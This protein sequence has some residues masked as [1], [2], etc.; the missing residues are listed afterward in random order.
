MKDHSRARNE[1]LHEAMQEAK[2]TYEKL[3]VDIRQVA[4]EAGTE[5]RT[6]KSAVGHWVRGGE[7]EPST[8]SYI[9]EAIS[10]RLGRQL[11]PADLGFNTPGSDRAREAEVGLAIGPDPVAMLRR[12]GEADIRRRKFL[13]NA[14]YSVAAAALPLGLD[15]ALEYRARAASKQRAGRAELD[16][17]RDM[18]AMFTAIDERHGGQ[19]GRTAVVQYL[20]SDVADLCNATFATADEHR[21]AL[22]LA[23]NVAYLCGWKGYDADEHG[24]AQRYYLQ[25]LAL[26]RE[27]GDDLHAAWILRIMAHNG[28]DIRRPQ[29]TLNLA[30]AALDTV[31]GRVA[32]VTEALFAVTRARALA[33][34]QRGR[35]AAAQIREAQDLV[36][37][38][39]PGDLPNWAALWGS[40]RAT[41]SS[42]TAKTFNALGDH[43]H[44][45][46]HYANSVRAR[47]VDHAHQRITALSLAAQG[48][49]QAAQGHV[50]AACSTWGRALDMFGGVRSARAAKQ[51]TGMRRQ[52]NTFQ[53]RGVRAAADL[54]E[55][56]RSWQASHA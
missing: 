35:E 29:H 3:A 28:M 17:V 52:L 44:A 51:V 18:T 14:A 20:R 40:P 15:Q 27:A 2:L 7:P 31:R 36:M 48:R 5:L 16:A 45:E 22:G 38:G 1:E 55:R 24:L 39:E 41:V 12:I 10:R 46:Q 30:E 11:T 21:E 6:N 34:A 26:T 42:H 47:N 43:V 50:E 33:T 23:A 49:E 4:A 8:A 13:T 25:A 32:P 53:R 37:T 54:D 19:H 56:A 9:A